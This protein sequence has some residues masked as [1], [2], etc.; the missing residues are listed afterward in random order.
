MRIILAGCLV[1]SA[2]VVGGCVTQQV[3]APSSSPPPPPSA[4]PPASSPPAPPSSSPASPS[5]SQEQ[6]VTVN[7][8]VQQ[9]INNIN[10]AESA[11]VLVAGDAPAAGDKVVIKPNAVATNSAAELAVLKVATEYYSAAE[12]GDYD[13]TYR[14]LDFPEQQTYPLAQWKKAN[15]DLGTDQARFVITS[16]EEQHGVNVPT[17]DVTVRVYQPDGSYSDRDT[18]FQAKGPGGSWRKKMT[19]AEHQLFDNALK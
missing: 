14:L 11:S 17:V 3:S 13:A 6:N 7:A 12:A 18:Y 5:I 4:P 1:A 8:N 19:Q 16:V 10:Q 9:A 15:T 2:L